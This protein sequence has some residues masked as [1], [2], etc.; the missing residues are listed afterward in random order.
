[1][2]SCPFIATHISEGG[3][4]QGSVWEY[5]RHYCIACC[6][7]VLYANAELTCEELLA[8]LVLFLY[9]VN[10]DEKTV[11]VVQECA[12]SYCIRTLLTW[13]VS[14]C[15]CLAL[16]PQILSQSLYCACWWQY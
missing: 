1:M 16:G 9:F 2:T 11:T 15:S 14:V 6:E 3:L 8:I 5:T 13:T 12:T 10:V 4:P 7:M